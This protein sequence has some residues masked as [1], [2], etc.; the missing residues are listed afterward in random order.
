MT[1]FYKV[2]CFLLPSHKKHMSPAG[3]C[4]HLSLLLTSDNSFAFVPHIDISNKWI[5]IE[6]IPHH[7]E[8][9]AGLNDCFLTEMLIW[10]NKGHPEVYCPITDTPSYNLPTEQAD[11]L[12]VGDSVANYKMIRMAPDCQI[13]VIHISLQHQNSEFLPEGLAI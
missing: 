4:H 10:M 9:Q 8:S 2:T 5:G 1:C 7:L 6:S 13:I 11:G 12:E 3:I